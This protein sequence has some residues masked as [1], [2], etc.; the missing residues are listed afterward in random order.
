[1]HFEATVKAG[2]NVFMEKP[3]AVD[4]PGVRQVFEL[5]RV[6]RLLRI[7]QLCLLLE[8][9]EGQTLE[10]ARPTDPTELATIFR[11]V[12][13]ALQAV[14]QAGFVHADIK[15]TSRDVRHTENRP[16]IEHLA[17]ADQHRR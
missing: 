5:H 11:E 15:P 1:M 6:R 7:S 16:D 8:Y 2:K 17:A 10:Q 4:A 9:L 12:A 3:V 14:H 13:A